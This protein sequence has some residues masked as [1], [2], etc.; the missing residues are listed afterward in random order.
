MRTLI[1]LIGL[2]AGLLPLQSQE[3]IFIDRPISWDETRAQLSLEYMEKRHGLTA[4]EP[5]IMPAMVVVHWTA[6]PTLEGSFLAFDPVK[7]PSTRPNLQDASSLNVS[8]PYLVDRD[9]KVY[10]LM[11]DTLFARHCIGLNYMAIGIENVGDGRRHKLTRAQLQANV[12]LISQLCEKHPIRF[13][14]GH[15]EYLNF[16]GSCLWKE[17]DPNYETVKTDPGKR[18]MRKLRRK[19]KPYALLSEPDC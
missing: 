14:I 16:K 12:Q 4:L 6:I 7:L 9:G 15:Y 19:L 5:A 17:S 2:Y 8:V 18:F 13:M 10:R 3:L 1:L 11:P